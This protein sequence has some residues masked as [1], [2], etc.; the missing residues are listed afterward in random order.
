[1]KKKLEEIDLA[2][3]I[4]QE[5]YHAEIKR[6]TECGDSFQKEL[7][8]FKTL[9]RHLQTEIVT[10]VSTDIKKELEVYILNIRK[11]IDELN[12]VAESAAETR[13]TVLAVKNEIEKFKSIAS[14]IK[15]EDFALHKHALELK[16]REKEKLELLRKI[17]QLERMVAQMRR[18][19]Q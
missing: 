4:R 19:Q 2:E 10:K 17:D 6:I 12:G 18:R 16:T 7:Q 9:R 5:K 11:K 14:S 15:K 3:K 1:M 13:D 8:E